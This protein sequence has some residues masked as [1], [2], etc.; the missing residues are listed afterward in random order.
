MSDTEAKTEAATDQKLRKK[1][2]EGSIASNREASGFLGAAIGLIVF[3][4]TIFLFWETISAPFYVVAAS[5][6]FDEAIAIEN[7]LDAVGRSLIL[8]LMPVVLSIVL[9]SVASGMVFNQGILF[10]LKPVSPQFERVSIPKGVKR[11]FGKRGWVETFVGLIRLILWFSAGILILFLFLPNPSNLFFCTLGCQVDIAEVILWPLFVVFVIL[12]IVSAL[13]E[14]IIQRKLFLGEQKMARSEVKK[15]RKE[16]FGSP[17]VRSERRRLR[18]EAR[19]AVAKPTLMRANFLFYGPS[20]AS[21]VRFQPGDTNVPAVMAKG[22]CDADVAGMIA[23]MEN[24]GC[25]IIQNE[26]L[27][28]S[29]IAQSLGDAIDPTAFEEFAYVL[30]D[31][32]ERQADPDP[33]SSV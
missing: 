29:G 32:L 19:T 26:K 5:L 21:A 16:S 33:E 18:E 2:R 30:K 12:F 6:T 14:I 22:K 15:E 11:I 20:V 8:S 3:V 28:R 1:R 9:T 25:H 7:V 31:I 24:S 17:E 4:S 23:S 13:F 10:S 27:A